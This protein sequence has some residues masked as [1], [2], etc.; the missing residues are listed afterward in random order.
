MR[1]TLG[2]GGT[3][4]FVLQKGNHQGRGSATELSTKLHEGLRRATKGLEEDRTESA[5]GRE[6]ASGRGTLL[7]YWNKLDRRNVYSSNSTTSPNRC[8]QKT[9][10]WFT[11]CQGIGQKTLCKPQ[12]SLPP[13]GGI[14]ETRAPPAVEPVGGTESARSPD[15]RS[16]PQPSR[17][18]ANAASWE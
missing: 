2:L 3:P 6:S 9:Q 15:G 1:E 11:S 16:I 14:G 7:N 12:Q 17:R 13:G 8:P 18:G 10:T 5:K 4:G